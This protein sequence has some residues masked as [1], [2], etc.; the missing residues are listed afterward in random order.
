MGTELAHASAPA[1]GHG[2]DE[3]M[4]LW[5]RLSGTVPQAE[6][7]LQTLFIK[8][9][10]LLNHKAQKA[11]S[12]TLESCPL[13]SLGRAGFNLAPDFVNGLCLKDYI[14]VTEILYNIIPQH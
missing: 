12:C 9:A 5:G 4:G 1:W 6:W 13:K 10:L 11:L 8:Q 14:G 2:G 7:E 3:G